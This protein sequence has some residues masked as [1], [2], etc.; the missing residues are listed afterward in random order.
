MKIAVDAKDA[1]SPQGSYS[2][3]ILA[4]SGG[5]LAIAGQ[6]GNDAH[7]KMPL[8]RDIRGQA[9]QA[10]LNVRAI[11]EA[12]GGSL[13]DIVSVTVHLTDIADLGA[14]NEVRAEMFT[15]PLPASTAVQV[16]ALAHP[17]LRVEIT[18][19]AVIER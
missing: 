17:S 1:P 10:F 15:E 2:N 13:A 4:T 9:R 18:A 11:A 6:V 3:A 12:A 16:T 7:L 8:G 5:I 14:V 19:L